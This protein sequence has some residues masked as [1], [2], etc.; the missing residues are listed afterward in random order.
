MYPISKTE[1]PHHLF[2]LG[3]ALA[4]LRLLLVLAVNGC[5][6]QDMQ[7][8]DMPVQDTPMQN[9]VTHWPVA[10]DTVNGQIEVYQPQPETMKGDMLTAR[11][12][13][14]LLR[15][16]A[17]TPIFGAAWFTAQVSTDRDTRTVTVLELTVNNVRLP[18]TTAA[19]QQNF[20]SIIG[21]Q[22]TSMEVT[23]PLDQLMASLDTAHQENI[24]AKQIETTPPRILLSTT[25]AT[26]ISVNG[27]PRLLPVTGPA[28]V[29]RVANTPFILL[30]DDASRRY[31]LKA[32]SRWVSAPNIYGPW[33]DTASVP[34]AIS[35]A[36][37]ELATPA[38]RSST[39]ASAPPA[40]EPAPA[41]PAAV[42][43]APAAA[44]AKIIVATDPTE[45]VVTTGDPQFTPT[46]RRRRRRASLR[47]QYRIGPLSGSDRPALLRAVVGTLVYGHDA[48]GVMAV[49]RVRSST[50]GVRADPG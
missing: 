22:L 17:S 20:A 11:A 26:L 44:D 31:Y 9:I 39:S 10:M 21:E 42:E 41:V 8:Q 30:L 23:C 29:S 19:E 47:E 6:A 12:V 1:K 40:T 15:P 35:A 7:M 36:G 28:S 24:Q 48:P 2:S 13:V 27:P 45:L 14:S 18:G 43:L 25:P 34:Q 33:A 3:S 38:P 16:G 4:F 50:A 32:G 37:E 49:R 46:A 5:V